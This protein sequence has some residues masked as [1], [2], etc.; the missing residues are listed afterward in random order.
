MFEYGYCLKAFPDEQIRTIE[1][2]ATQPDANFF[3]NWLGRL[4]NP[5]DTSEVENP[6]KMTL[7]Q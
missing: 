2:E 7:K 5:L 4:T 6:G 3:T 1:R